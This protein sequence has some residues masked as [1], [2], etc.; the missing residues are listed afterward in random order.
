MSTPIPDLSTVKDALKLIY[1]GLVLIKTIRKIGGL[2][3]YFIQ[4]GVGRNKLE[5]IEAK[6]QKALFKF[7]EIEKSIS[8]YVDILPEIAIAYSFA[9][10]IQEIALV[11]DRIHEDNILILISLIKNIT[12]TKSKLL[13]L[14]LSSAGLLPD[15]TTAELVKHHIEEIQLKLDSLNGAISNR[16][17][18]QVRT[19]SKELA[20]TLSDFKSHLIMNA[21]EFANSFR[22]IISED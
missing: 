14:K 20:D 9:D 16:N 6:I 1:D 11:T 5:E 10:K 18:E 7:P 17:V 8:F 15:P 13:P 22:V 19:Y 3:K 2:K 4:A 21:K 12:A